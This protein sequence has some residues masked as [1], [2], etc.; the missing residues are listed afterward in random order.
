MSKAKAY[1]QTKL[2]VQVCFICLLDKLKL[3]YELLTNL[4]FF[5]I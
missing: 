2:Y 3:I 4:L 5:H 1:H